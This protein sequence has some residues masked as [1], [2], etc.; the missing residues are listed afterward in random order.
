LCLIKEGSIIPFGPEL[1]YTG[2][3]IWINK[4]K[5]KVLDFESKADATIS[6]GGEAITINY[7]S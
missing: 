6:Y 4:T 1:Q 5:P 2:E 3:I 7:K